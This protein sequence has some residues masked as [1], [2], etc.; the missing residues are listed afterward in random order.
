M[1]TD[2]VRK[3]HLYQYKGADAPSKEATKI[4]LKDV[5]TGLTVTLNYVYQA[6]AGGIR[7]ADLMVG[8]VEDG[9][10][11]YYWLHFEDPLSSRMDLPLK[12]CHDSYCD[13]VRHLVNQAQ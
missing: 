7:G 3:L 2:G 8:E 10:F 6:Y 1:L 9:S 11:R 12:V 4:K 5:E 13:E